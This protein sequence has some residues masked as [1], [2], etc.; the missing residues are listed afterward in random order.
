MNND[1]Q[2]TAADNPLRDAALAG[3]ATDEIKDKGTEFIFH[4]DTLSNG[5]WDKEDTDP[6]RPATEKDDDDA[7]EITIKPGITEGEVWLDHPA[8]AGLSFYKTRECNAADKVNLSPSSKFSVSASNPF[9]DKLFMRA[10]VD[11]ALTYPPANPQFAGDLVLKIKVGTNG[12]EIEAVKMKLT[13]VKGFGADKYF[14]ATRDYIFESNTKLMVRDIKYTSSTFRICSICEELSTL[15]PIETYH[16]DPTPDPE[17]KSPRGIRQ[18]MD[19]NPDMTIITNG[20]MVYFSTGMSK[21]E[22]LIVL[23]LGST[24]MTDKCQGG[25]IS[26]GSGYLNPASTEAGSVLKPGE[27]LLAQNTAKYIAQ[28]IDG[29]WIFDKGHLP[30]SPPPRAGLGGLSTNYESSARAGADRQFVGYWPHQVG[31]E[32]RGCVF[33][34]THIAGNQDVEKFVAAAKISKVP[35]FETTRLKLFML[36]SGDAAVAL[37]HLSPN[38]SLKLADFQ[39]ANILRM[40]ASYQAGVPYFP[41]TYMAFKT[42]KP[43][44]Q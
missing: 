19:V 31:G 13:V 23:G 33:T 6:A 41:N 1:G 7:E 38:G 11:G 21:W 3:G 9:P 4:N 16:D 32:D 18:V 22:S 27:G 24:S 39:Q 42:T 43:R 35:S 29:K 20:N 37:A 8:I 25:I 2:I 15:R 26:D 12:Q 36:D 30:K 34:A 44:N 40:Q 10:D 28:G 5:I 17:N 14:S